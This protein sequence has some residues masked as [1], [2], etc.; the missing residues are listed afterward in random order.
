MIMILVVSLL[1]PFYYAV[2]V[3]AVS[4]VILAVSGLLKVS[5]FKTRRTLILL[6]TFMAYSFIVSI[7]HQ[8]YL[9]ALV[10]LA[11][12]LYLV[13]FSYY[14]EHVRPHII[15]NIMMVCLVASFFLFIYAVLE[16]LHLVAEW[17]YSFIY[18]GIDKNHWYRSEAFF[19][20]PNYYAMMLEFF[21]VFA[22]YKGRTSRNKWMKAF[23]LLSIVWNSVA[24]VL[25]ANRT[26][27]I[28]IVASIFVFYFICGYK[29]SA[30]SL[31]AA[32]AILLLF[33]NGQGLLPRMDNLSF[34]TS[35][36]MEIWTA[37]V[38]GIRDNWLTGQGPMTYMHVYMNYTDNFTQHA[39]NIFLDILL[40]YGLI[41]TLLLMQPLA[42]YVKVIYE[43]KDY[44]AL[45][46]RLGLMCAMITVV[47]V[48]GLTDVTILWVQ[49]AAFFLLIALTAPNMLKEE[50]AKTNLLM[51]DLNGYL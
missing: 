39:H 7:Y 6:W 12:V 1:L 29:K 5:N 50:K 43:M 17:D 26:S 21:I 20:N 11:F 33:M 16:S 34:A 35:D 45:R 46:N 41:G 10:T 42:S 19:A 38:K 13:Y 48:H 8:N 3:F 22:L 51:P 28:V 44:P 14:T 23:C 24:I 47:I 2:G 30:M 4:L 32:I 36:R 18:S 49:T 27:P 9:G 31:V 40:N 37:A 15:E 25:A